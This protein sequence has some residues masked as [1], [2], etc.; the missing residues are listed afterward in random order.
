MLSPIET[1]ATPV[2]E[3]HEFSFHG[4]IAPGAN[5]ITV[6]I[7]ENHN[8]C[9]SHFCAVTCKRYQKVTEYDRGKKTSRLSGRFYFVLH[10]VFTACF[11]RCLPPEISQQIRRN[12]EVSFST[13]RPSVEIAHQPHTAGS[14]VDHRKVPP[15]FSPEIPLLLYARSGEDSQDDLRPLLRQSAFFFMVIPP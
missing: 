1:L 8:F 12:N 7:G 3:I 5:I 15:Q 14:C 2:T 6:P 9:Y 13:I 11:H 10:V 4:H